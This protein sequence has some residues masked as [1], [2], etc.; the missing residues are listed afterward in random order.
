M[1]RDASRMQLLVLALFGGLAWLCLGLEPVQAFVERVLPA[2]E[3]ERS[4]EQQVP[5]LD[6][7]PFAGG[8]SQGGPSPLFEARPLRGTSPQQTPPFSPWS[9]PGPI[10]MPLPAVRSVKDRGTVLAVPVRAP[11]LGAWLARLSSV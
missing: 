8:E 11:T 9:E 2:Q 5:A 7:I 10:A 1:P 3:L 4:A 6:C